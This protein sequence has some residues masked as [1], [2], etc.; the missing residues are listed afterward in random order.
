MFPGNSHTYRPVCNCLTVTD[1][2]VCVVEGILAFHFCLDRMTGII[3]DIRTP[4]H[5]DEGVKPSSCR[6]VCRAV[7]RSGMH[8]VRFES[9]DQILKISYKGP[10]F[11]ETA[12]CIEKVHLMNPGRELNCLVSFQT[13]EMNL[14]IGA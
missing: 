1:K 11:V 12:R 13:Q 2:N 7:N 3:E 14:V 4:G 9:L 10:A 5:A 6:N 8:K